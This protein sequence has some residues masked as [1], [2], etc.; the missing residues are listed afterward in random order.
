MDRNDFAKRLSTLVGSSGIS[1][2]DLSLKV[3]QNTGY[4]NSIENGRILPSME[5]FF[6]ICEE[7]EI[8]PV[9]FFDTTNKYP[10]VIN[11][12]LPYFS[13]LNRTEFDTIVNLITTFSHK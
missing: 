5:A 2:R 4:I 6:K 8:T 13:S 10:I 3:G 7:L 1:A 12:L 9:E 11:R